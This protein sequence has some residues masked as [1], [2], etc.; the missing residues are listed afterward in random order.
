MKFIDLIFDFII[1]SRNGKELTEREMLP[2]I[3]LFKK[4]LLIW[5]APNIIKSWN[6]FEIK[7][8]EG[9]NS[10]EM[11]QEMEKILREIRKD[12]GHDDTQLKPGSLSGLFIIAEEKEK[13]LGE[14]F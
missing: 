11:L 8:E 10:E 2:K 14:E 13:L 1:S 3:I 9:L 6:N 4:T 12:L 5:G 7:S